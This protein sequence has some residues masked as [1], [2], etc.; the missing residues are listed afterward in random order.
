M[1]EIHLHID[2]RMPPLL[3]RYDKAAD[4]MKTRSHIATSVKD[5]QHGKEEAER[6]HKVA[7]QVLSMERAVSFAKSEKLK[8]IIEQIDE[9]NAEAAEVRASMP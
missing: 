4:E 5:Q 2:A 3:H 9:H 6:Q 8:N 7:T 1:T